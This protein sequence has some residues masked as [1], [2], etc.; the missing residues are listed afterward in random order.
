M[1]RYLEKIGKLCYSGVKERK[2]KYKNYFFVR[3]V[4]ENESVFFDT[5]MDQ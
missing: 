2:L 3:I 4:N 1:L 5:N